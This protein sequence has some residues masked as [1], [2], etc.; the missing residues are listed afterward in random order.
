MSDGR[1]GIIPWWV[2]TLAAAVLPTLSLC[3]YCRRR[4]R[5]WT[6][7]L[8]LAC[9]YDLRASP[10]RCPECGATAAAKGAA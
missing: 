2:P 3:R 8:C 9:G 10:D 7:G 6:A 5:R 4:R 1:R